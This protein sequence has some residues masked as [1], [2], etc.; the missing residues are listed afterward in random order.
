[1]VLKNSCTLVQTRLRSL[2]SICAAYENVLR[3]EIQ[4]KKDI[5][6]QHHL[7]CAAVMIQCTYRG[8]HAR[9]RLRHMVKS[10]RKI[11]RFRRWYKLFH[12]VRTL[13]LVLRSRRHTWRMERTLAARKIQRWY[14]SFAQIATATSV[15][16]SEKQKLQKYL[17]DLTWKTDEG[18]RMYQSRDEVAF[19]T[20]IGGIGRGYFTRLCTHNDWNTFKHQSRC[21]TTIQLCW[22]QSKCR[23]TVKGLRKLRREQRHLCRRSQEVVE[24]TKLIQRMYRGFLGRNARRAVYKKME[25]H[26]TAAVLISNVW[27]RHKARKVLKEKM[28]LR[29][30]A[31]FLYGRAEWRRWGAMVIQRLIRRYKA[32]RR[33]VEQK[34]GIATVASK[35]IVLQKFIR[36]IVSKAR[37]RNA[38]AIAL[39]ELATQSAIEYRFCAARR[40]QSWFRMWR[41][42]RVT[43]PQRKTLYDQRFDLAARTIQRAFI[44]YRVRSVECAEN[45]D[46]ATGG[47]LAN[48]YATEIQRV[49]RG[50][51]V[52]NYIA[53][54]TAALQIQSTYRN[55]KSCKT[56]ERVKKSKINR[57]QEKLQK[58]A[59][60]FGVVRIQAL[61]RGACV[62]LWKKKR[63]EAGWV[64]LR[65]LRRNVAKTK[66]NKMK[67]QRSV[68]RTQATIDERGE[69]AMKIQ[70]LWRSKRKM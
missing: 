42:Q 62:R 49:V 52:R 46:V 30:R 17:D 22:R 7:Y 4:T 70:Q 38:A 39:N 51:I 18:W 47:L 61:W 41:M 12:M 63:M 21:A 5:Q 43:L 20:L 8:H 10:A 67:K 3:R 34:S 16:D 35:A 65:A 53:R 68:S 45:D 40:I 32:R 36:S 37:V 14:R 13:V 50:W 1:M 55:W 31:A 24:A 56:Q 11:Q 58:E 60:D 26:V 6:L 59:V 54:E 33:C 64:V 9:C 29:E 44:N 48:Q 2:L 28:A 25:K 57:L 15:I 27:L 19:Q 69:A 66:L 23:S